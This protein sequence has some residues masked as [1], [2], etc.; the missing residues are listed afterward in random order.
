M[1]E[2]EDVI[3]GYEEFNNMCMQYDKCEENCKIAIVFEKYDIKYY[4]QFCKP[5][6]LIIELL[7]ENEDSIL[8]YEKMYEKWKKWEENDKSKCID[9]ELNHSYRCHESMCFVS[10]VAKDLFKEV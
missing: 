6:Y 7:G 3:N 5:M 1:T 10:F 4:K 8:Y 9:C 2:Y